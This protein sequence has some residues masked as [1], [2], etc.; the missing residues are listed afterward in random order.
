[1]ASTPYHF[2]FFLMILVIAT[3]NLPTHHRPGKEWSL[4]GRSSAGREGRRLDV[5]VCIKGGR[6]LVA[7]RGLA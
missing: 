6:A 1:M 5:F 7:N 3:Q 4:M 2:F